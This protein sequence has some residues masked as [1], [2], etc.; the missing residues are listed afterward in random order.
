MKGA[1]TCSCSL[2]N[3]LYISLPPYS[4]VRQVH[5]LQS[6][7]YTSTDKTNTTLRYALGNQGNECRFQAMARDVSVFCSTSYPYT[8][9]LIT[10]LT[11]GGTDKP[12]GA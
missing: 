4:C 9:V 5:T 7:P 12:A 3:K 10:L 11:G 1:E 8:V 2:C 6:S